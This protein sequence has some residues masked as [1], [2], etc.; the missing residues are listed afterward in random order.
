MMKSEIIKMTSRIEEKSQ[1]KKYGELQGL[2]QK[3][4]DFENDKIN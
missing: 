2:A 3:D 1:Y 4:I